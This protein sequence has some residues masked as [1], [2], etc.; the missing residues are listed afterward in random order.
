MFHCFNDQCIP[1]A[2]RCDGVK[3]CLDGSDE[4]P[5]C[6]LSSS[7]GSSCIDSEFQCKLTK[8]C[9]PLGWVCDGEADCGVSHILGKD[10]SDE[11]Q[12]NVYTDPDLCSANQGRCGDLPECRPLKFFCDGRGHCPDNSD[13]YDFCLN[14]TVECAKM[15]CTH[16][17]AI[18]Q[19]GAQCYCP[20]GMR[21]LN[22]SC[23]DEDE[24]V[25]IPNGSPCAQFCTNTE[26]SFDCSCTSGYEKTGYDC[27][28]I[29]G[30]FDSFRFDQL[31]MVTNMFFQ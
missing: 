27:L 24:C 20:D 19:F 18:T 2:K 26:G 15:K 7:P 13:E 6:V 14:K 11:L 10:I 1:Q 22:T 16:D 5:P 23:V 8:K 28:A 12:C 21:A 25:G 17:C 9:I 4:K 31:Y 30:K 29:N 3:N